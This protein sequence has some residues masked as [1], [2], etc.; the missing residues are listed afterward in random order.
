[1]GAAAAR[2]QLAARAAAGRRR[3]S[4]SEP[5]HAGCKGGRVGS[6]LLAFC[7][8]SSGFLCSVGFL[9]GVL[10]ATFNRSK[11]RRPPPRHPSLPGKPRAPA[12]AGLLSQSNPRSKPT[13]RPTLSQWPRLCPHP[14]TC[15]A[16]WTPWR[17]SSPRVRQRSRATR[18]GVAGWG[19]QRRRGPVNQ[20]RPLAGWGR[21]GTVCHPRDCQCTS[22]RLPPPLQRSSLQAAAERRGPAAAGLP[23]RCAGAAGMQQVGAGQRLLQF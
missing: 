2:P 18:P 22:L 3:S 1:M 12:P 14:L 9:K 8:F 19:C 7:C 20:R 6:R 23:H 4:S 10:F 5:L 15:C 16:P 21:P 17:P 11:N 13:R